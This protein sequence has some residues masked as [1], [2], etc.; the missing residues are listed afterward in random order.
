MDLATALNESTLATVWAQ[1]A[2]ALKMRY[3]EVFWD[4]SVGLY[5]DNA[6]TT[7]YPQDANSFA[8]IYNLTLNSSQIQRISEGLTRNWNDLGPVA[9]ELPDTISPF[10]AGFEVCWMYQLVRRVAHRMQWVCSFKR[11]S[12]LGKTKEHWTC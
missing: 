11:I 8:V 1:N 6:T 4:N 7:L 10:I 5:R 3:N 2:T 12:Y 9:P